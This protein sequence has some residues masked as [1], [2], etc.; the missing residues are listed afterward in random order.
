MRRIFL[1]IGVVL[2]LVSIFGY[3]SALRA[4]WN[5]PL[6]P[7]KG[8]KVGWLPTVGAV[9]SGFIIGYWSKKK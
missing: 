7:A 2:L 3:Y 5:E 6:S 1:T 8:F 9:L 4:V